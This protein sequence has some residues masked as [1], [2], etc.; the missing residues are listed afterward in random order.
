MRE[1]IRDFIADGGKVINEDA[2][3]KLNKESVKHK[4][5]LKREFSDIEKKIADL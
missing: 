1:F 5:E 3:I 2:P 4:E